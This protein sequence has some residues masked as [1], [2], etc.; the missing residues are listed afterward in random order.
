MLNDWDKKHPGRIESI[1]AAMQNVAP[2]QLADNDLFD[3][4][5]LEDGVERPQTANE[6]ANRLK[7]VNLFRQ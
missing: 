6:D 1:F 3:F 5:R 4:A 7:V 2:S